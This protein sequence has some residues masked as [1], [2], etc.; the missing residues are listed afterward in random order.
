MKEDIIYKDIDKLCT[1]VGEFVVVS[2]CGER[3]RF[4]VRKNYFDIPY[5]ISENSEHATGI[6]QT[7][8]NYCILIDSDK[9]QVGI[10]YKVF[11]SAGQWEFNDSDEHT[12]CYSTVIDDWVVGIGA[13][14][15]N[16]EEKEDQMWAYSKKMGY[17]DQNFVKAPQR[18]DESKFRGYSVEALDELNGFEFV[19]YDKSKEQVYFE[20]AWIKIEKYKTIEYESAIGLWLY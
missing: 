6:I 11:F 15:P 8:T 9:L 13:Y 10:N 4:S 18:F 16:D 12:N 5:E 1:P 7:D 17:L 19:L 3:I 2:E 20:V 14:D